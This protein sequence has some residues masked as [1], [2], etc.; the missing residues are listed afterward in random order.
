M[1]C[2]AFYVENVVYEQSET[3]SFTAGNDSRQIP[4]AIPSTKPFQ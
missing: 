2:P 3:Q 4:A 1:I